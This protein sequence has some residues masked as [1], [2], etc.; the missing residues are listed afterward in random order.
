MKWFLLLL[1]LAVPVLPRLRAEA[2]AA[3]TP[4]PARPPQMP[5]PWSAGIFVATDSQPYRG[6][7]GQSRILPFLSYRSARLDWY[8]PFLRARVA[9]AGPLILQ[10]RGQWDFG[11]YEA[12]DAPIL[13]GLGNR[14]DTLL[15]GA[16]VETR[17]PGPWQ[18][19]LS[20]DRD[21]LGRHEG[22]EALAGLRRRIGSPRAPLSGSLSAGLRWQDRRWT[23][24]R[25][26]VPE[27]K[28]REDRPAYD[29][30]SSLHPF[31][32]GLVLYRISPR[33]ATTLG[34][35]YEWLDDTW[36]DSPLVS[37]RGRLTSMLTL[38]ASF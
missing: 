25:V 28:A 9:E 19:H 15:L 18:L 10:A 26:G 31:V 34:V 2:D 36:R 8:G 32:G 3:R 1:L 14:R 11:A 29:P 38:S 5:P 20:L 22:T 24:D 13:E 7:G 35:R 33:W 4:P 21:V 12:S 16:G 27:S 17:F 30:G 6:A 23:E 37:D